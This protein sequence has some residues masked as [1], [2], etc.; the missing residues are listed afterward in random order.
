M[1]STN[2]HRSSPEQ[3]PPRALRRHRD[4]FLIG[5]LFVCDERKELRQCAPGS[6]QLSAT[7]VKEADPD[8]GGTIRHH[9]S[10]ANNWQKYELCFSQNTLSSFQRE[11]FFY[12]T[13]L[14]LTHRLP[15]KSYISNFSS[16][17]STEV[18]HSARKI[19]REGLVFKPHPLTAVHSELLWTSVNLL[20]NLPP[21][22][23]QAFFSAPG[24]IN[25]G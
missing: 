25:A 2:N 4:S 15:V 22:V 11:A 17:L 19:G 6:H 23:S 18:T 13:P 5:L 16:L 12:L 8:Q 1:H 14:P 21:A 3:I 24:E 7:K 9:G 10:R 20:E